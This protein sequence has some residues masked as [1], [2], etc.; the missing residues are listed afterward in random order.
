MKFIK[1]SIIILILILLLS[2]LSY[3]KIIMSP[4]LQ[5]VVDNSIIV[6]VETD[7]KLPVKVQYGL[8]KKLEKSETTTFHFKTG[9]IKSTY[10]HRIKLD[11]LISDTLYHYKAVQV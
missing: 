9:L 8:N 4:Y 5:A 10:V 11:N 1:K 7:S 3:S 2:Q 6:M